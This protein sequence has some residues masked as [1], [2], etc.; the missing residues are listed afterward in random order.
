MCAVVTVST[1]LEHVSVYR[2]GKDKSVTFLKT[3]VQYQIVT[4]MAAVL[5]ESASAT[6]GLKVPTVESVRFG[7]IMSN[8]GD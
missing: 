8:M 2:A 6:A 3:S 4:E 1:S 5:M 7:F